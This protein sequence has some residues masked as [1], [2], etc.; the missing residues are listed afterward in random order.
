MFGEL[1]RNFSPETPWQPL[2]I[3]SSHMVSVWGLRPS[4]VLALTAGSRL[5]GDEAAKEAKHALT[6][7]PEIRD[8][9]NVQ[10]LLSVVASERKY[11][12]FRTPL[13]LSQWFQR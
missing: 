8:M 6:T 5:S 13:M 12:R 3:D 1:N 9:S 2:P 7:Y 10:L 11:V 4:R